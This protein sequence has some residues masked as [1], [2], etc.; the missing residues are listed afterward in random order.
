MEQHLPGKNSFIYVSGSSDQRNHKWTDAKAALIPVRFKYPC[1][2][3][4][5]RIL[6]PGPLSW[7]IA[8]ERKKEEV[9]P[10]VRLWNPRDIPWCEARGRVEKGRASKCGRGNEKGRKRENGIPLAQR[11]NTLCKI[12]RSS[13]A[14]DGVLRDKPRVAG[15]ANHV[16]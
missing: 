11:Y 10:V 3:N 15:T 5:I 4:T 16:R 2:E 6:T 12:V 14:T 1:S 13:L 7:S 9:E 8:G